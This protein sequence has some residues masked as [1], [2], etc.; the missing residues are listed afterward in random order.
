MPSDCQA[1]VQSLSSGR[2]MFG[3]LTGKDYELITLG[4]EYE[5]I[6]NKR[7]KERMVTCTGT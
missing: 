1:A 6:R 2:I 3:P 7:N 5:E 4:R